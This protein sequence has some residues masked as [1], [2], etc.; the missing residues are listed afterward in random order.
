VAC[1]TALVLAGVLACGCNNEGKKPQDEV[2]GTVRAFLHNCAAQRADRVLDTLVPAGRAVLV[3]AGGTLRGCAAILR[4]PH[5][6]AADPS[7]LAHA[8]VRVSR[9]EGTRAFAAVRG[10]GGPRPV[11]VELSYGAEGWLIEGPAG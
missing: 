4:E 6:G 8:G 5:A 3:D 1:A 7:R 10:L 2:I 11:Q 9:F